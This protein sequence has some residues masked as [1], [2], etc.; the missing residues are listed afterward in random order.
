MTATPTPDELHELQAFLVQLGAAMNS[1]GEPVHL[2]QQRLM[3]VARAAGATSV[4]ITAFPTFMMLALGSGEPAS[5]EISAPLGRI[6]RLDQIAALDQL[7]E[8]ARHGRVTPHDGLRRLR[9]ILRLKPRFGTV[10]QIV[11]YAVMTVGLCL[12]LHPA[13][14]DAVAA[15]VLGAL[16]GAL[17]SIG[18]GQDTLQILMPVVAAFTVAAL[19]ALALEHD[20]V[21]PGLR[22]MVASLIIFL[23]G[24]AMTTAVLELAAGQVVSGASRLVA[25]A[26]Q[27]ALLAFG[28]LAGIQAVGVPPEEVFE[29]SSKLLETWAPWIGVLLFACGVAVAHSSPA[30]TFPGLLVVLYATYGSQVL[31]NLLFGGLVSAFVGALVMT[32][33]ALI[34][35]RWRW[36]MPAF[37]SFLPGFWLLVPGALGLIG[38]TEFAGDAR[39][40]GLEDLAA[41]VG[42]I[43]AVALGVLCGTQLTAWADASRRLVGDI[44]VARVKRA[45]GAGDAEPSVE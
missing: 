15:A 45:R 41:T 30:R 10:Q 19:S 5:L 24:S 35:S 33:V 27:L 25:G 40:T 6:P 44:A 22:P 16:V 13:P 36:G 7:V 4:R 3:D 18:R 20:L 29:S 9:D 42:L 12:I 2:V 17:I 28:I 1:V 11:A 43:L 34:V 14:R 23:P 8:E 38:L 21:D 32:P 39:A 37:A 31:A 26:M